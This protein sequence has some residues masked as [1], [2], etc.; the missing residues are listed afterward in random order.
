ML[1]LHSTHRSLMRNFTDYKFPDLPSHL[2]LNSRTNSSSSLFKSS[3][4][5]HPNITPTHSQALNPYHKI[6]NFNARSCNSLPS[7]PYCLLAPRLPLP[8]RLRGELLRRPMSMPVCSS[9]PLKMVLRHIQ[10][11]SV[12][13]RHRLVSRSHLEMS[14]WMLYPNTQ[15]TPS[16]Q[17]SSGALNY[18]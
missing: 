8:V 13:Y 15:L 18:G 6:S 14:M 16:S 11:T 10:L 17:Y 3:N 2:D 5:F 9:N 1:T 7:P 12:Q 4:R